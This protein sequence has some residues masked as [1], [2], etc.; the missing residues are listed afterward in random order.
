M[1]PARNIPKSMGSHPEE[2]CGN[3]VTLK[4]IQS[5]GNFRKFP[6]SRHPKYKPLPGSKSLV[7]RPEFFTD[8]L[9]QMSNLF[10]GLRKDG[11]VANML[12]L[13]SEGRGLIPPLI[14]FLYEL[15]SVI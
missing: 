1:P 6:L 9:S 12:D 7:L 4:P 15:E 10:C 13:D 2:R 11:L 3:V 14:S 5:G 8:F